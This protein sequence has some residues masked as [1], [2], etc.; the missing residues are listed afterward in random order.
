M[1]KQLHMQVSFTHASLLP[2][3]CL[4]DQWPLLL[5]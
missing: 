5:H 3:G 4:S 1:E 2:M